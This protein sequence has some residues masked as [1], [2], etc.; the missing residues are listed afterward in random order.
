[1]PVERPD[2]V[3]P[4]QSCRLDDVAGQPV[5]VGRRRVSQ[6]I[7]HPVEAEPVAELAEMAAVG[8]EIAS[9]NSVRQWAR[10]QPRHQAIA[11]RVTRV[12]FDHSSAALLGDIRA[13]RDNAA[14][15][16]DVLP[17]Q[18]PQFG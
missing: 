6:T 2:V 5:A 18:P 4:K 15:Q 13:E 3:I 1:V 12:H 14:V 7:L 17:M 8:G 10:R 9:E 16:V 11:E